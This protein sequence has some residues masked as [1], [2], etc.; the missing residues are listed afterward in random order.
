VLRTVTA[1]GMTEQVVDNRA[2]YEQLLNSALDLLL[3]N[4]HAAALWE[5]VWARHQEWVKENA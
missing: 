2:T 3:P 5:K 1:L 4:N